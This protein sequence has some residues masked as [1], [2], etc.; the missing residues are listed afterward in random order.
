MRLDTKS[1][2]RPRII[3]RRFSIKAQYILSH[4]KDERFTTNSHLSFL[5]TVFVV[6]V[7]L[8]GERKEWI[9]VAAHE[10]LVVFRLC[11][12]C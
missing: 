10:G 2:I 8:D 7:V 6:V 4:L 9:G 11:S 12:G 3:P 1:F 5:R